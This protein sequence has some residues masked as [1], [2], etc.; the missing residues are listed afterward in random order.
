MAA[1]SPG[2]PSRSDG[3]S[4]PLGPQSKD[5]GPAAPNKPPTIIRD[6]EKVAWRGSSEYMRDNPSE[7]ASSPATSGARSRRAV[8]APRTRAASRSR[9]RG[10]EPEL[11]DH[12]VESAFFAAIA[13]VDPLDVEG[14]SAEALGDTHDLAR[15]HEEEHCR[16]IDKAADEPRT[17]NAVD[18]GPFPRNPDCEPLWV[19]RRQFAFG[20]ERQACFRPG[21]VAAYKNF[22]G[23]CA[24][25][26]QPGRNAFA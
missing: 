26:T 12:D 18:L 9:G 5:A 21:G 19:T 15:R 3:Y 10:C 11:L 7:A 17:R 16:W 6:R 25:V 24:G 4:G 22:G 14:R 20:D 1:R 8:S 13:P 2:A 23:G